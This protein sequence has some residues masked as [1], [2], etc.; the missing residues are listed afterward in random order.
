MGYIAKKKP[1]S[2]KRLLL[3]KKTYPK[4]L[5][6]L[7]LWFSIQISFKQTHSTTKKTIKE[8]KIKN[9]HQK[10]SLTI[11]MG[12]IQIHTQNPNGNSEIG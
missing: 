3:V 7:I 6:C 4:C 11:L 1:L 2:Q 9:F 10:F 12:E 8:K 5:I